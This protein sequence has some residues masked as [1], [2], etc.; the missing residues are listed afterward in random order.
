M[1]RRTSLARTKRWLV[2]TNMLQML[3]IRAI[4]RRD[5]GNRH[6]DRCPNDALTVGFYAVIQRL[7]NF[8]SVPQNSRNLFQSVAGQRRSR[9]RARRRDRH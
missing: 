6:R 7:Q 5:D 2:L 3:T 4:R 9:I 8:E 1:G